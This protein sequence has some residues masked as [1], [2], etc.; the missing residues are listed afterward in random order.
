[1]GELKTLSMDNTARLER[2]ADTMADV[3]AYTLEQVL[4]CI[5][6][7]KKSLAVEYERNM[8]VLDNDVKLDSN[9]ILK[10]G[11]WID[12]YYTSIRIFL[13]KCGFTKLNKQL[14]ID[15]VDK[16]AYDNVIYQFNKFM[17]DVK[18]NGKY[19]KEIYHEIMVNWLKA[20]DNEYSIFWL[21]SLMGAIYRNQTFKGS[22][23]DYDPV[24]QRYIIFGAQGIGKSQF[25]KRISF[26]SQM[27]FDGDLAN[28]D[29]Q[30]EITSK[31]LVNADDKASSTMSIVDAIK[32]AITT[33]SY[34][35]RPAYA[36]NPI[37]RLNKAVWVGSTNRLYVYSDT[38]GN[39]REMPIE[40]GVGLSPEECRKHGQDYYLKV[41]AKENNLFYDL[42][43][44]FLKDT[45]VQKFSSVVE[46]GSKIDQQRIEI[47]TKHQMVSDLDIIKGELLEKEVPNTLNENE[48]D[49]I[50]SYLTESNYKD[51]DKMNVMNRPRFKMIKLKDL[52]TIKASALNK[53]I[54]ILIGHHYKVSLIE[55]VMFD[56]GFRSVTI[57]G[58]RFYKK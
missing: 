38:T 3:N 45:N 1:M 37:T 19:N 57:D 14:I 51:G 7:F 43:F 10:K 12:S 58:Y 41:L 24:P 52:N 36:K 20:E 44:T 34:T 18:K 2:L 56:S 54:D 21:K 48:K 35:F 22:I 31:L 13:N 50:I 16:M 47:V 9:I 46:T 32:S 28:R 40:M 23:S 6:G 49:D 27:D 26:G 39:R 4:G 53:A 15:I 55:S 30:Q 25:T 5:I 11:D 8:I 33:P 42:W 17:N 29:A